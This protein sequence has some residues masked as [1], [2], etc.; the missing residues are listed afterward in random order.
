MIVAKNIRSAVPNMRRLS[1]RID[2][3]LGWFCVGTVLLEGTIKVLQLPETKASW[4]QWAAPESGATML[5]LHLILD[6]VFLSFRLLLAW[7][8]LRRRTLALHWFL[9]LVL[10]IALSGLSG[11]MVGLIALVHR[12][13]LS[14]NVP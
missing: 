13:W 7:Y 12:I 3:L 11:A 2:T 6:S 5:A 10:L 4:D 9:P 1:L 8:L 14:P